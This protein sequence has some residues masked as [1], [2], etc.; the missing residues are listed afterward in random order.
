M[1]F[2]NAVATVFGGS[3]FIGRHLIRR[4]AKEG[5]RIRVPTRQPER[6]KSLMTN[7]AVGQIAP[8]PLNFKDDATLQAA[9]NGADI[10]IN[11][12][13]ILAQGRGG[14]FQTLQAELPGRI[15]RAAAAADVQHFVQISAIGAD[16]GSPSAY[17]RTKAGRRAGGLSRHAQRHHP[18]PQHRVRARG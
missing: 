12:I 5:V 7:G 16:G 2:G 14:S 17:A 15:A 18:A 10:V 1:S 3:G 13:G 11:L 4:L 6:V 8:V 9:V